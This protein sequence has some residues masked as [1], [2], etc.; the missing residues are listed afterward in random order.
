ML[1]LRILY[2][3]T[4]SATMGFFPAHI[5][6]LQD[7]GHQVD[8][9][10]N[11]SE[12]LP[13]RVAALGCLA[14]HIP[15]SR[16]PFSK[17]NLTAYRELQKLLTE[18]HYDIVHTHTPNASAI[19]RLACRKLQKK[20]LRVFYTAHGF[21]FY[22]GAPL[23]NWLLYYPVERF[24]SRW[25][26]VL[27]TMNQEDFVRA[28]TFRSKKVA[29][30]HGVGVDLQRFRLDWTEE[31]R[32]EKRREMGIAPSNFLILSVGELIHRKNHETAIRAVAALEDPSVKYL[33]CGT[34][35]LK[36]HL[37]S[38]AKELGISEQVRLLGVRRDIGE[39]NQAADLFLFP[40]FQEGLPVA[41]M[42]AMAAGNAVV[43]SQI[44]GNVD[45]VENGQGRVL[46]PAA[47]AAAFADAILHLRESPDLRKI[48]GQNNQKAVERFSTEKVLEELKEIYQI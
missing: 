16:A 24:L 25:T 20:G 48:M 18:N 7:A 45:L 12:P 19:T 2:V 31:Q 44:R 40:S 28:R 43:C 10:C 5:K 42:E 1:E 3:T 26:D 8:L 34:G 22:T 37:E 47:D 4:V 33:I 15:F 27:I 21:H 30:I 46:C 38:L 32:Q 17:D 41:L 29:F 14:H 23:K 36:G 13:E 6:M 9:A 11:L 39:L 35:L